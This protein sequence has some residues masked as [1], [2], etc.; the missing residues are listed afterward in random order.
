LRLLRLGRFRERQHQHSLKRQKY[1]FGRVAPSM[2]STSEGARSD[3]VVSTAA[4]VTA[5][6]RSRCS[7]SFAAASGN[8]SVVVR[9]GILGARSRN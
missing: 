1:A 6:T 8:V 9:T 4:P 7:A 3:Q 5:P 2:G